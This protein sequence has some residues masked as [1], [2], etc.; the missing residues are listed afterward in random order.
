MNPTASSKSSPLDP[1]LVPAAADSQPVVTTLHPNKLDT[2]TTASDGGQQQS[3]AGGVDYVQSL[4]RPAA[5]PYT[6]PMQQQQQQNWYT[7][8]ME[9]DPAAAASVWVKGRMSA[10][11][12]KIVQFAEQ[13]GEKAQG[14]G[15]GSVSDSF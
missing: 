10:G 12:G 11:A 13:F 8:P 14:F 7:N 15:A 2:R 1:Y 6:P 5:P 4:S 3:R 9:D